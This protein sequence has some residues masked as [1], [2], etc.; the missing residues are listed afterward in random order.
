MGANGSGK[1]NLFDALQL[2]GRLA[3]MDVRDAFQ[4]IR[5]EPDEV[6]TITAHGNSTTHIRL[7]AEMFVHPSVKDNL[8]REE[9]LRTRRLRYE[10]E[11]ERRH[12]K[13]RTHQWRIVFESLRSLPS[14]NDHW[15]QKYVLFPRQEPL[16]YFSRHRRSFHCHRAP[17]QW[18]IERTA[19]SFCTRLSHSSHVRRAGSAIFSAW[20]P[21]KC[22]VARRH[23][24]RVSSRLC[25]P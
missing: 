10:I 3:Q 19:P 2:L 17:H 20:H 21:H 9:T 15:L 4:D 7:A 25:R 22:G 8:G 14:T 11:V 5:G 24:H 1:S 16:A 18:K 13:S 12:K 23:D 6:F